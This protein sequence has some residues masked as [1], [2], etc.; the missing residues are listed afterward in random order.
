MLFP[1]KKE[2]DTKENFRTVEAKISEL[3]TKKNKK[4]LHE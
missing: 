1:K 3:W 4:F 2:R